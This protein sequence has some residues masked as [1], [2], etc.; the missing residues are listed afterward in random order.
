MWTFHVTWQNLSLLN[1]LNEVMGTYYLL[2]IEID[3]TIGSVGTSA[4]LPESGRA[5]IKVKKRKAQ[6]L[7]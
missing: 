5:M 3:L 7:L 6:M 2:Y 4:C 1:E